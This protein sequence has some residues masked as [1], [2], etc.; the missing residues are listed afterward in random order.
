MA[1]SQA[2][3]NSIAELEHRLA[4]LEDEREI[5]RLQNIYGFYLD[6]RM[7]G[8]LA[9]LFAEDGEI[10]IGRRGGY[11]GRERVHRFLEQVLGQ[12]RWGL[13]REEVINH[14]QLQMV[15]S[16]AC[17]RHSAR[18]RSRALIQGNSPPGQTRMLLAEGLYENEYVRQDGRW[19]V[20]R[21]WWVPT[22]YF[23]VPGFDT[24]VFESG[25][26]SEAFPP[27]TPPRVMHSELGRDFPPFHYGH[28]FTG[29]APS[30]PASE[31]R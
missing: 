20:K 8:E 10:E 26:A 15:I 23:T 31:G 16:V 22:Y 6:N 13:L 29:A 7:W 11:R 2:L 18:M 30:L 4:L 14:I 24:A 3:I 9:A 12:G 25:P 28:P 27:D 21:L 17:D 5:A 1:D 19:M